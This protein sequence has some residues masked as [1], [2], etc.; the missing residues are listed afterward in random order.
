MKEQSTA[1]A[2]HIIEHIQEGQRPI[3]QHQSSSPTTTPS[4]TSCGGG[5]NYTI[6]LRG[7]SI[8]V[9]VLSSASIALFSGRIASF[10]Y[11]P[12]QRQRESQRVHKYQPSRA[13]L[14][15]TG[16]NMFN[17]EALVHPA[18]IT[19]LNPKRVAVLGGEE[20]QTSATLREVLKHVSVKDAVIIGSEV[21]EWYEDDVDERI[22][23]LALEMNEQECSSEDHGLFF[24]V[25]IDPKPFKVATD[26]SSHFNCL[27]DGGVVSVSFI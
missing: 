11:F 14:A 3:M 17:I 5:G 6:R 12:N 19:H 4:S 18:M 25:I 2:N 20:H 13:K 22:S 23:T 26:F 1:T 15:E 8:F 7:V 9:A 16:G 10:W 24:D 27:N 21:A